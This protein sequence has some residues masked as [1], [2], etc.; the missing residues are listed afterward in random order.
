ME[1]YYTFHHELLSLKKKL[2]QVSTM[3]EERVRTAAACLSERNDEALQKL[4]LTDYEVDEMEVEIEEDCLK[5]LA[6]HQPVASDLRFI[7]A[8]IKINNEI[9]RIADMAVSI[10]MR[11]QSIY[12]KYDESGNGQNPWIY[13]YSQMSD[14]VIVMLKM[15]LDAL[16]NRDPAMARQVFI[17]D[18]DVDQMMIDAYDQVREEIKR[19]PD[20]PGQLINIYLVARHLERIADRSTNISEEVIHLVEGTIVRS[21]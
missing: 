10:A 7:I 13:D 11:I 20:Q 6:L 8:V 19:K 21:Q 4:I 5:I 12:K 14:K 3:V 17:L 2:M 1:P 15:S 9:E 18:D 16:V